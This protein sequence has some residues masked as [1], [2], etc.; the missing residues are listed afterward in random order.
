MT[1]L[2]SLSDFETSL[3]FT[4]SEE[5]KIAKHDH[6]NHGITLSHWCQWRKAHGCGVP[7]LI[8]LDKIAADEIR[9]FYGSE[10]WNRL[11]C[12]DLPHGVNLLLFD[13]SVTVDGGHGA[14]V[15]CLQRVLGI[16][17]T[18]GWVGEETIKLAHQAPVR[19]LIVHFAHAQIAYYRSLHKPEH[20]KHVWI[21][22]T[23]RREDAAIRLL[24]T[25]PRHNP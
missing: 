1:G 25:Y 15:R 18:D 8:E 10:Y 2:S 23:D 22:R 24:D 20:L 11:R 7:L 21:G 19:S 4:L 5:G 17:Q 14:S 16:T 6:A 12:D 9:A 13:F 3:Q